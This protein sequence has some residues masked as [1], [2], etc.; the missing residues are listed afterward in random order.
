MKL[1][2]SMS[3]EPENLVLELLRNIRADVARVDEKVDSV[4]IELRSE[5]GNAKADLRSEIH[6]LRA[7]VAADLATMRNETGEQIAGLRR[8]VVEYHSA[9][10][11]HGILISDLEARVRRMEDHL[12]LSAIGVE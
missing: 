6:S 5:I 4:K 1:G 12:G 10:P 7:D 9:V 2:N 11:G 3:G 8:A